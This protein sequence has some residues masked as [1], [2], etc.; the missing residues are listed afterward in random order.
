[1]KKQTNKLQIMCLKEEMVSFEVLYFQTLSTDAFPELLW[2][3]F[4]LSL[5][6]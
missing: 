3:Y 6:L 1:M 2:G 4:I 5:V